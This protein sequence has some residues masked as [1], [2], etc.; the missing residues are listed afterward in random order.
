MR[1][2]DAPAKA[3]LRLILIVVTVVVALYLI[4]L[5]RKPLG[6]VVI[7]T[8]FAVALSGPVN[9]LNQRMRRGFAITLVYLGLLAVPVA[10]A[11]IIIP[12]LITEGNDLVTNAPD[13]SRDVTSFVEDNPTLKKLNDDYD[14]TTKIEEEAAKLPSKI[15]DAAKILRDVGFGVVNSLF[16]LITILV[17]A[18]FMLGSGPRWVRAA[19]QRQPPERAARLERVVSRVAAAVGAYVAGAAFIAVLAGALGFLVLS[20]LGVPFAGPLA[21]VIGAGSLIPL[22]GATIAAVIVGLVTVFS[23]FPVATIVWVVY[24]IVYQQFENHVIQPQVQRRALDINPFVVVVAVLCG[25]TLLGI[26]GAL[27]AIPAA[28]SIQIVIKEI[29]AYRTEQ[30]LEERRLSPVELSLPVGT[31][32]DGAGTP[33]R[34]R[35][36][37]S[38]LSSTRGGGRSPG[39][40]RRATR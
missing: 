37:R 14:V 33:T 21:V 24:A 3:I 27:L 5:L 34:M 13:Y 18:A 15:G 35:L 16:A 10:I 36:M 38:R 32:L 26:V 7:A 8:F 29:W 17:L 28:A 1:F 9:Y 19:L 39:A 6:W 23:N 25:A 11:A 31:G 40:A 12:P 22:I 20:I 2:T 30:R 4:Y